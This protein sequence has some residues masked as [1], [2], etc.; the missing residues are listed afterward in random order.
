MLTCPARGITLN[1]AP[2]RTF[3]SIA[4]RS[5]YFSKYGL[6]TFVTFVIPLTIENHN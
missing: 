3:G 5:R 1:K 4:D 6:T 2:A